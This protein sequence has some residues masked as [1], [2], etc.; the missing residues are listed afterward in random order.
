[1][2]HEIDNG[3]GRFGREPRRGAPQI[4]VEHQVADDSD[5]LA[6]KARHEALQASDGLG[7]ISRQRCHDFL[8]G[9]RSVG[10]FGGLVDDQHRNLVADRVDPPAGFAMEPASSV[11]ELAERSLALRTNENMEKIFRNRHEGSGVED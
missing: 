5:S 9:K 11:G 1:M 8:R 3:D 10:R 4:T 2:L 7:E 6:A